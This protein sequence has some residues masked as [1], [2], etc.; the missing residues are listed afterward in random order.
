MRKWSLVILLTF[1]SAVLQA[2]EKEFGSNLFSCVD[3]KT[4]TI[5]N[6]C[7]EATVSNDLGE[8]PS[9][10]DYTS[11][12]DNLGDNALATMQFHPNKMLIEVVARLQQR[13]VLS[14]RASK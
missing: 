13:N 4:L 5:D 1:S 9:T 3:G 7:T 12:S 6:S 10:F 14:V 11:L 8:L 2:G